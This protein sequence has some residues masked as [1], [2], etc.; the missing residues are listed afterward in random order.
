[1]SSNMI[2]Y[3]KGN[4]RFNYRAV[5]VIIFDNKVLIHRAEKDDFWALPGGRVEF[6]EPSA[7]TLVREMQEELGIDVQVQRLLW[8]AE[9]FFEFE[10]KCFHELGFYHLLKLQDNCHIC[11]KT[12]EFY[13]CEQGTKLIF[14]WYPLDKLADLPLY[15]VFLKR[16]LTN[17]KEGI[18]HIIERE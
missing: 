17:I 13:G 15:P 18:E 12:E 16:T 4:K 14:R 8:I 1:M 7:D 11:S 2:V 5:G 6:L 3:D 9:N 10:G